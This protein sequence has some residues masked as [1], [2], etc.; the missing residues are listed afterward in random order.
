MCVEAGV[1]AELLFGLLE[2][3][4]E[5]ESEEEDAERACAFE[6]DDSDEGDETRTIDVSS[7]NDLASRRQ[8]I[9]NKIMAVGRMQRVFALLRYVRAPRLVPSLSPPH[10]QRRSRE[11]DGAHAH[12]RYFGP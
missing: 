7:S 12:G 4:E 10:P 9:K 2:G 3:Y 11:R 5:I 1:R 6:D 8:E